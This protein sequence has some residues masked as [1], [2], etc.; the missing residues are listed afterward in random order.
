MIAAID[1]DDCNEVS[2]IVI[3]AKLSQFEPKGSYVLICV[4]DT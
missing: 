4:V 2:G 3:N 1:V